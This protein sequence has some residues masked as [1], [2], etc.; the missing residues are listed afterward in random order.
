MGER[1][2][3]RPGPENCVSSPTAGLTKIDM[4][5]G[6]SRV[7]STRETPIVLVRRREVALI[8]RIGRQC[9]RNET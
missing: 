3:L 8:A 7:T 1:I 6:K 5:K 9:L 2:F 4:G